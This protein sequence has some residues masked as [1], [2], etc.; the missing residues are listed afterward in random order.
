MSRA[1]ILGDIRTTL[2]ADTSEAARRASVADRL[3]HPFAHPRP[4]RTRLV[5]ASSY[6]NS[7]TTSGR[8]VST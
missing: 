6:N 5:Q 1:R 2:D 8:S 7:R 4:G 3:A